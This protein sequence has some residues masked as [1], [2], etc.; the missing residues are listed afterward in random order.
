MD[1]PV[2]S[3]QIGSGPTAPHV[4]SRRGALGRLAGLLA[5]GAWPGAVGRAATAAGTE[6]AVRFVVINDFHHEDADCDPW[7][8][9]LFRQVARTEGAAF[10]LGLGDLANSGKRE[11]LESMA[12]LSA[13]AGMP[14]HPTPG[15]HDLDESPVEGYYAEVF[16]ERRNYTISLNGWQ[17]V[18]VDTTD[19]AK[20]KDTTIAAD[21]FDWLRDTMPSLD[22]EAPTVLATHF[23]LAAQVSMCPLNAEN[24]L[25]RFVGYNLR[26]VFSGHFHGQTANARGVLELVTNVCVSRVR[27]NHDG[28]NFKGYW[29]CD[30]LPDGA[31]RREFVAFAGVAPPV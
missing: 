27:G 31:L 21:T 25:A 16:P 17:F 24:L 2:A 19:G 3:P 13:L 26:G 11:S 6:R 18:V 22:P 14:F 4:L 23:P 5:A 30:G 9:A 12:R 8:E 7:M 28:T 20:W 1:F 10:C 15:N 29:V